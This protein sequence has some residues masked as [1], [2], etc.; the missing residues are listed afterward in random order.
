LR[1]RQ[2]NLLLLA[3]GYVRNAVR[4]AFNTVASRMVVQD[5]YGAG[6][7][8]LVADVTAQ[9]NNVLGRTAFLIDQ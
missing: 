2:P 8:K 7:G 6:K 1:F 5:I 9:L 3:D 4:E